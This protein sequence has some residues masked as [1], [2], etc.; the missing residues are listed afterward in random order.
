MMYLETD[1]QDGQTDVDEQVG[2]ASALQ[3]DTHW[4]ED[5]GE[6]DLADIAAGLL[7]VEIEFKNCTVA[8]EFDSYR[9][10]AAG[11]SADCTKR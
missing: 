8:F 10:V 1:T 11:K 6:D 3:E 5:D 2:T 4:R 9:T 7:V